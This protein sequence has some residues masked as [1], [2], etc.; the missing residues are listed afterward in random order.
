MSPSALIE[1]DLTIELFKKGAFSSPRAR[2]AVVCILQ[3][4]RNNLEL[5]MRISLF[6]LV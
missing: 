5:T 4:M 3:F 1:L 6:Y 2:M